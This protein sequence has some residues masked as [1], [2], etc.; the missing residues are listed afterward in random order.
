MLLLYCCC[1]AVLLGLCS[2]MK[3]YQT[4]C[5]VT[6][7]VPAALLRVIAEPRRRSLLWTGIGFCDSAL[8][9]PLPPSEQPSP[10]SLAGKSAAPHGGSGGGGAVVPL[11]DSPKFGIE[12]IAMAISQ[13]AGVSVAVPSACIRSN[14][15]FHMPL[16]SSCMPGRRMQ[17]G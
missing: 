2:H 8:A 16:E 12:G 7:K 1:A 3:T 15:C 6:C 11:A 4:A 13:L 5:I 14:G 17:T 9:L 10:S